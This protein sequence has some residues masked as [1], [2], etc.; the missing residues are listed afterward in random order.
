MIA[1]GLRGRDWSAA[2]CLLAIAMISFLPVGATA[3][4]VPGSSGG[5][6]QSTAPNPA[7]VTIVEMDN[8]ACTVTG[9]PTTCQGGYGANQTFRA[10]L[11]HG[12]IVT[13]TMAYLYGNSESVNMS[14]SDSLGNQAILVSSGCSI[15][16]PIICTA[17]GFFRVQSQGLDDV[18]FT[19]QGGST[20]AMWYNAEIWQG[21]FRSLTS[22]GASGS[23]GQN[24]TGSVALGPLSATG[25]SGV[26]VVSAYAAVYPYTPATWNASYP[27]YYQMTD[28]AGLGYQCQGGDSILWQATTSLQPSYDFV[29][30]TSPTPLVWAG[31]GLVISW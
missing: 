13:L 29:A 27:Y 8:D 23:C 18:F 12:E 6:L 28:C 24:C 14:F 7:P 11:T 10:S 21:K 20:G 25:T 3:A 1:P 26:I 22:V 15:S 2:V 5:Q 4:S 16:S 30:T 19:E 9:S 31:S 17:V